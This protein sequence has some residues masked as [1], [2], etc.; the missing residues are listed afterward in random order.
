ML[1]VAL[2]LTARYDVMGAALG[3]MLS[4]AVHLIAHL[5][6]IRKLPSGE[7]VQTE[8]QGSELFTASPQV[9]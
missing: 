5:Y 9:A 7:R 3:V 1:L 2:P 4:S 6:Y 8:K